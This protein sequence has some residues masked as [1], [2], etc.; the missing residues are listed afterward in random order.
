MKHD[1]AIYDLI[2]AEIPALRRFALTLTRDRD[3]ADDLAQDTL[4]RAINKIEM[5]EPGTNLRAWLFTIARRLFLNDRRKEK[6][7][8]T[9]LS[10]DDWDSVAR[11]RPRQDVSLAVE[12]FAMCFGQLRPADQ[13]LLILAGVD[14]MPYEEIAKVLDVAVGTVKSR[15]S[16]A[17]NR[18]RQIEEEIG[19]GIRSAVR[20][21]DA[22]RFESM[23]C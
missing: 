20:D 3:A 9:H 12:D 7:Q 17:R 4:E 8:G 22:K 14:R 2:E 21:D 1:E 15:V 23:V 19:A 10:I 11:S 13:K 18:L 5:F 6:R 16:R